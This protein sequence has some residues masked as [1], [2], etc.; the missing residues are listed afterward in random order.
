MLVGVVGPSGAGKDTLMDGARA[1]LAGDSGFLFVRRVITRPAGAGGEDHEPATVAEFGALREAGR[2][3]LWWQAHGLHY[4]IPA[5]IGAEIAAGRVVVANLSRSVLAEAVARFPLLVLHITAPA[6][7]LAAR[8]AA[9]GR[10]EAADVAARLAR[11]ATLPPGLATRQVM[12]DGSVADG[13]A[14]VV[15]VLRQAAIRPC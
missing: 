6:P 14:C 5:T 8:L 3:A 12:N 10:E 13:V 7:L 15:A 2:L 11:E 1:A 9:R 4:G